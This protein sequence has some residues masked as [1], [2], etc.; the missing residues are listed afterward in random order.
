MECLIC[1]FTFSHSPSITCCLNIAA[2]GCSRRHPD[3]SI[4]WSTV[5]LEL[6]NIDWH[7]VLHLMHSM[8]THCNPKLR[9]CWPTKRTISWFNLDIFPNSVTLL[10]VLPFNCPF[11]QTPE[12]PFRLTVVSELSCTESPF[13]WGILLPLACIFVDVSHKSKRCFF[14]GGINSPPSSLSDEEARIIYK[15]STAFKFMVA[16]SLGKANEKTRKFLCFLLS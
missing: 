1:L 15:L 8:T 4:N 9:R 6:E 13:W 16:L 11:W 2:I 10:V 7:I 12:A 5:W 3:S 14:S